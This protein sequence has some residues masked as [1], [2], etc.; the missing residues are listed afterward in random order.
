MPPRQTTQPGEIGSVEPILGLLKSLKIRAR[1]WRRL[2]KTTA[3]FLGRYNIV[4]EGLHYT[5]STTVSV[6]SSELGPP[7]PSP[8]KRVC[9]LPGTKGGQHFPAGEGMG[10]AN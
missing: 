7:T 10:G 3:Y 8:G 9:P 2:R 4:E 6:P 1:K 5:Y